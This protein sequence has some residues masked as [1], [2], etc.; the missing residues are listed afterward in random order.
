MF[1]DGSGAGSHVERDGYW[2]EQRSE[3]EDL[4]LKLPPAR[5]ALAMIEE[6]APLKHVDADR[7]KTTAISRTRSHTSY[8]QRLD[9]R[10]SDRCMG[11][12]WGHGS[13]EVAMTQEMVCRVT[14]TYL[15]PGVFSLVVR[16]VSRFASA[17]DSQ[18]LARRTV[19]NTAHG[20]SLPV[21]H[22]DAGGRASRGGR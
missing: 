14:R 1:I 17:V 8:M 3:S 13:R 11:G 18:S 7:Q 15:N 5:R 22:L 10:C 20:G 9:D 16:V 6:H 2:S 21:V 12:Y 4:I 19:I